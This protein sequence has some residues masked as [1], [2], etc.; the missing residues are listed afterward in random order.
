MDERGRITIPREIRERLGLK[1]GEKLLIRVEGDVIVITRA[2]NPFKVIEDILGD[3]SFDRSLRYIAEKQA[4]KE[5][6]KE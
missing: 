3:L 5:L 1:P 6:S 2:S 4:F